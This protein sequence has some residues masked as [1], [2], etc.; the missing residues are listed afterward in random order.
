MRKYLL[1]IAIVV[2]LGAVSTLQ[3]QTN[4]YDR[5]PV[6][7]ISFNGSILDNPLPAGP[8]GTPKTDE[9]KKAAPSNPNPVPMDQGALPSE[10]GQQGQMPGAAGVP[11][12]T[13]VYGGLNS[14]VTPPA[15]M[16]GGPGMMG[17]PGMCDGGCGCCDS[18]QRGGCLRRLWT[19]LTFRPAR[20]GCNCGCGP[21]QGPP[22][23]RPPLYRYFQGANRCCP[24]NCGYMP[25]SGVGCGCNGGCG[26]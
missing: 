21:C 10:W 18:C 19:W 15:G 8:E 24:C 9:G 22:C 7:G 13:N 25:A 6:K 14:L 26:F 5:Y 3:A 12:G 17:G 20:C 1:T 2:S 4:S 23:C 11:P 16:A